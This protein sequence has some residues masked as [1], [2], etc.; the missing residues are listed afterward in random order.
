MTN[1][2]PTQKLDP[3]QTR[4]YVRTESASGK[5]EKLILDRF[6][7]P[8]DR[9]G[10]RFGTQ[11]SPEGIEVGKGSRAARRRVVEILTSQEYHNYHGAK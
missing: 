1:T 10:S 9:W 7:D 8:S 6:I 11:F 5:V 4:F 3:N 2:K